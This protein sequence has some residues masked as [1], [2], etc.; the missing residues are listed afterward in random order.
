VKLARRDAPGNVKYNGVGR[1]L[2]RS[3][4]HDRERW[5]FVARVPKGSKMK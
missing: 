3:A 4:I 5:V 1:I 2:S